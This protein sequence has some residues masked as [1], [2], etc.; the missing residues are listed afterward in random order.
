M[1]EGVWF[2]CVIFLLS[3]MSDEFEIVEA[4]N[5]LKLWKN[6]PKVRW[7]FQHIKT[8]F[9]V[10]PTNNF[11][12]PSGKTWIFPIFMFI[13]CFMYDVTKCFPFSVHSI[14]STTDFLLTWLQCWPFFACD[15]HILE[16]DVAVRQQES[17]RFSESLH[18]EVEHFVFWHFSI[19][20]FSANL[21]TETFIHFHRN[22]RWNN[23]FS[24]PKF[25]QIF[26]Q[27]FFLL[28][29]N[30]RVN[31]LRQEKTTYGHRSAIANWEENQKPTEVVA[32]R[33]FSSR[34]SSSKS[35]LKKRFA[36]GA[37]TMIEFEDRERRKF[38]LRTKVREFQSNLFLKF[39]RRSLQNFITKFFVFHFMRI[40][41]CLLIKL[42][43]FLVTK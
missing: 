43:S 5:F 38:R 18:V 37:P 13:S 40:I 32:M 26:L 10:S 4:S 33:S 3:G 35:F 16:L 17:Q 9:K 22:L 27:I 41:Y 6:S 42:S 11:F 20:F 30:W 39:H 7:R 14:V 1:I 15:P 29:N 2:M 36:F 25:S 31:S 24:F 19:N 21:Q 23:F 28:R 8:R 34:C 12:C